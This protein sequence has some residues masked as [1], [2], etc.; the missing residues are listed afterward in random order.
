MIPVGLPF[1][2]NKT[3]MFLP[4]QDKVLANGGVSSV[5]ALFLLE[6]IDF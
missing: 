3:A 1:S 6:K 5:S 4:R 2:K